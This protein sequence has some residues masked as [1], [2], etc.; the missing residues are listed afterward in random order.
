MQQTIL[1]LLQGNWVT[2]T[3]G[4]IITIGG[5][6]GSVISTCRNQ[7]MIDGQQIPQKVAVEDITRTAIQKRSRTLAELLA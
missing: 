6:V 4:T 1:A 2:V 5:D 3:L 7:V